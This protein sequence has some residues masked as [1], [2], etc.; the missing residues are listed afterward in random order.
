MSVA[1]FTIEAVV[2]ADGGC[3]DPSGRDGSSANNLVNA[4]E[5][6]AAEDGGT[7]A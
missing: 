2:R 4:G 6:G 3:A 1:S 5:S 7:R